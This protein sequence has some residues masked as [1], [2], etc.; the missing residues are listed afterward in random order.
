MLDRADI[1]SLIGNVYMPG[2]CL[3]DLSIRRAIELGNYQLI[4]DETGKDSRLTTQERVTYI[5][6]L[7]PYRL[8]AGTTGADIYECQELL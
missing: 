3:M 7:L 4:S 6:D 2:N 1:T 8:L 5:Q